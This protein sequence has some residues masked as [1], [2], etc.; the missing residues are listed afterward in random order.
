MN[1]GLEYL[2]ELGHL[3][4]ITRKKVPVPGRDITREG[5]RISVM[6]FLVLKDHNKRQGEIRNAFSLRDG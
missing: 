3:L 6:H 1:V 4:R 2:R 5:L